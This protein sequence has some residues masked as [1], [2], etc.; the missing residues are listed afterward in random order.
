MKKTKVDTRKL[1]LAKIKV[2]D[3]EGKGSKYMPTGVEAPYVF[4]YD[5]NGT[6]VNLFNPAE[7]LPICERAPYAICDEEGED[8]A[9][10]MWHIAGELK[11]GPFYLMSSQ[12]CK[13]D[14]FSE[15]EIELDFLKKY[16]LRSSRFFYDRLEIINSLPLKERRKY[17]DVAKKDEK[18]HFDFDQYVSSHEKGFSYLKKTC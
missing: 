16:M 15:D 5:I 8:Y 2:Y 17:K 12:S 14:I 4:L 1:R 9:T 11:D 7:E 3:E 10:Y 13:T 18:R 6:Y